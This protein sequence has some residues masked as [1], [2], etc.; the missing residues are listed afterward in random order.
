MLPPPSVSGIAAYNEAVPGGITARSHA[1]VSALLGDLPLVPPGVVPVSEWRPDPGLVRQPADLYAALAA[2]RPSAY[3]CGSGPMAGA[4]SAPPVT[5][6]PRPAASGPAQPAGT[7]A[8]P[9]V[10]LQ[11][12]LVITGLLTAAGLTATLNV[13]RETPDITARLPQAGG[14]DITII[15]DDDGYIELRYWTSPGATPSQVTTSVTRA[16]SVITA[17]PGG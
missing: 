5:A 10:A 17:M 2:T 12:M 3:R 9:D 8:D 15:I 7:P 14:R 16:I 13:T 6:T 1:Q 4:R 11:R